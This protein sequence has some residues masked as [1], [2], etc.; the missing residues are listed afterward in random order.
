MRAFRLQ[1]VLFLFISSINGG[2]ASN[3]LYKYGTITDSN[4]QTWEIQYLPGSKMVTTLMT[5]SYSN[6]G[7]HLENLADG[8]FYEDWIWEPFEW[9]LELA[10]INSIGD[11]WLIGSLDDL[12]LISEL[13]AESNTFGGP[14]GKVI[15]STYYLLKIGFR[16]VSFPVGT[17][18]G[19]GIAAVV[20]PVSLALQPTLAVFYV[21][22]P[23]SALPV[24]LYAYNG[25][26]FLP[27]SVMNPP[28]QESILAKKVL[29][30]FELKTLDEK[31]L[32]VIIMGSINRV[33]LENQNQEFYEEINRLNKKIDALN[34]QIIKNT[35]NPEENKLYDIESQAS[36]Q[37]FEPSPEVKT[38]LSE[39]RLSALVAE[40]YKKQNPLAS[41]EQIREAQK[42]AEESVD[43]ILE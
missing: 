28:K 22:V 33:E 2:L 18:V 8:E 15:G 11:Y 16:T 17:A 10:F 14:F 34:E 32:S 6:A 9:G 37:P 41:E 29:P 19:I 35:N 4:G 20:P 1:L 23:G 5:D 26:L 13:W 31:L 36:Y 38:I 42:F 24:F 7:D 3:E 43:L 12:V 25:I 21:A 40:Q 39:N 30:A 27:T